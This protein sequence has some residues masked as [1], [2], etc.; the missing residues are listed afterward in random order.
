MNTHTV[1]GTRMRAQNSE[2]L[3]HMIWRERQISRADIARR[4]GLS[5]STVS[6]IVASQTFWAR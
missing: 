5:P 6:A 1:D 4:S 2:L 3:L